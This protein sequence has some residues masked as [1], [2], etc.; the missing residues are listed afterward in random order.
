M[1]S[2]LSTR[3]VQPRSKQTS[4][5]KLKV[6][7][8]R[9]LPRVRGL[10]CSRARK[11]SSKAVSKSGRALCGRE[12]FSFKQ[13]RPSEWKAWRALRTDMAVQPRLRAIRSG[14]C[15]EAL[16]SRIWHRRNSKAS[17]ERRPFSKRCRCVF[18]S[19]PTYIDGFIA[20]IIAG[21]RHCKQA[22]VN[23]H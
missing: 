11:G 23:L 14:D 13:A 2:G 7:V 9:D 22:P 17:R 3:G 10:R 20:T 12:D 16:A 19:G 4:A 18:D 21:A 1:A 5:N 6:Q 15:P 8:L